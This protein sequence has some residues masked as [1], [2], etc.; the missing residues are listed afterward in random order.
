LL[1]SFS[2][3][4]VT[5]I[6]LDPVALATKL[7]VATAPDPETPPEPSARDMVNVASP[8]SLRMS[9]TDVTRPPLRESRSPGAMSTRRSTAG[10]HLTRSGETPIAS[11]APS[12]STFTVNG[13]VGDA[14]TLPGLKLTRAPCVGAAGDGGTAAAPGLGGAFGAGTAGAG[15]FAGALPS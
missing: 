12:M 9:L 11:L 7:N 6:V 10:S 5:V 13:P 4:S 15:A 8:A 1:L 2:A 14:V 3:R